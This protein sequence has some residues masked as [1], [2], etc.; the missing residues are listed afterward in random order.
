MLQQQVEL[1]LWDGPRGGEA[2]VLPL[3]EGDCGQWSIEVQES[4]LS[5]LQRSLVFC[6]FNSTPWSGDLQQLCMR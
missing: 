1:L 6:M 3:S 5:P 2:E 4:A